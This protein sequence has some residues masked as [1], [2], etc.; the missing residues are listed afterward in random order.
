MK[1]II[2]CVC[3]Q[4]VSFRN[5]Y[6]ARLGQLDKRRSSERKADGSNPIGP[7]I[8]VLN[9]LRRNQYCLPN[10]VWKRLDLPE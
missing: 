7:K 5:G 6:V 4:C 10:D 9:L 2:S 1:A 8:R 3:K